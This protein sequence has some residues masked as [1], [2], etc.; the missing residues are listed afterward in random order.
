MGTLIFFAMLAVVGY[1]ALVP[2]K[3]AAEYR[4]RGKFSLTAEGIGF[5]ACGLL[6]LIYWLGGGWLTSFLLLGAGIAAGAGIRTVKGNDQ[7][8]L[9]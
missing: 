8:Y 3:A 7:R 9:E 4:F 2:L 6:A 5:L 1:F